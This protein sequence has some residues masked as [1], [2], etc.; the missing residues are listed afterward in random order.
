[1]S[2]PLPGA[3]ITYKRLL[4]LAQRLPIQRREEAVREIRSAF[5]SSKSER[6]E[7]KIKA[8]L[9]T[10]CSQLSYLRMVTP[11][12]PED[13]APP[14]RFIVSDGKLVDSGGTHGA[15]GAVL[16]G[17]ALDPASVRKH[18]ALMDRFRFGGRK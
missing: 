13:A 3:L 8:L 18:A 1:M 12:M 9:A 6:D 11:K 14:G 7:V 17:T 15:L 4:V 2:A 16:G 5:R 10:A